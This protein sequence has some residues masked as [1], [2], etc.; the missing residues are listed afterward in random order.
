MQLKTRRLGRIQLPCR[1]RAVG[2]AQP[3][4]ELVLAAKSVGPI[5]SFGSPA[6]PSHTAAVAF[7]RVPVLAAHTHTLQLYNASLIPAQFKAFVAGKG[8]VFSIDVRE[9]E[10]AAGAT[11]TITV[12]VQLDETYAFADTLHLLVKD[13]A[14]MEVPLSATGIGHTLY[15]AA[16]T[17]KETLDLGD[18][19]TGAPFSRTLM[20]ENRGRR[21]MSI[22][23]VNTELERVKKE[24]GKALRGPGGKQ[25]LGLMPADKQPVFSV[26]PERAVVPAKQAMEFVV[27]GST[28]RAAMHSEGLQLLAGTGATVRA[29]LCALKML[30]CA[31]APLGA[32]RHQRPPAVQAKPERVVLD[33]AA[34]AAVAVPLLA[35][36]SRRLAFEYHYHPLSEPAPAQHTV[37]CSNVSR[38]PLTAALKTTPPFALD[39]RVLE[40]APGA[41]ADVVVT[42]QHAFRK[43]RVSQQLKCASCYSATSR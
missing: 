18:Q 9:A 10:L 29:A 40:L 11:T 21:V 38:L 42:M 35:F 37:T 4:I 6:A 16:V 27:T 41:A 15:C 14:E 19:F 39:R 22:A 30:V 20:L 23:W 26:E 24:L 36:S 7:G 2:S 3:P 1:I 5:L 13:G 33:F 17:G 32:N 8:S 12:T 25:D 43:D 28:A 31:G 34:V